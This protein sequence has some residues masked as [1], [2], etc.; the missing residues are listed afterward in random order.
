[1]LFMGLT[2][3]GSSCPPSGQS[4]LYEVGLPHGSDDK[5]SSCSAG[6]PGLVPGLG[7]SVGEGHG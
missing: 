1:M 5:E 7:G 3:L 2:I 4:F 6:D